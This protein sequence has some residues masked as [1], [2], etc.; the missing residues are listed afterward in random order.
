[1]VRHPRRLLGH[2]ALLEMGDDP[3]WVDAEERCIPCRDYPKIARSFR[4]GSREFLARGSGP[5]FSPNRRSV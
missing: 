5:G 1:M 2:G 3:G 4:S